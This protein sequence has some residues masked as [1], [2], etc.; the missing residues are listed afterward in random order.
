VKIDC[1]RVIEAGYAPAASDEA[2]ID[3]VLEPFD[4]LTRGMG[5]MA[6]IVDFG[7]TGPRVGHWVPRGP[8]PSVLSTG[9]ERMY[10]F[11]AQ[12]HAEVLRALLCPVPSVVCWLTE[13][14]ACIPDSVRPTTRAFLAGSG[15]KDVLG[16][17]AAEPVGPSLLVSVPYAEEVSIPPRTMRQLTRATAHLCSAMRLRRRAAGATASG[18]DLEPDVEAVL[19]PSGKVL[20]ASGGAE[21]KVARASLGETVRRVERARG[22]LR[23]TD[24][25]EALSIWRAL[26]DGRWSVV[27][28][29]EADGKRF[30]LAR[31]NPPGAPDPK[32]LTQ[33]ERDVLACVARGH[34]NKYAGYLLGVATSTVSSRLEAALRKLGVPSR[35]QAIELLGGGAP[36]A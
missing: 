10:G 9:W 21:G 3:S 16:I 11:L 27:E 22:R 28:R 2:W 17:L 32:A 29:T 1:L 8:V 20:H 33:G 19:D 15:F 6:G 34:S 14:V 25:E 31:L 12:R 30:M 24:P 13:R 18:D 5:V 36:S 4:L 7:E 23:H 35:R 26:F